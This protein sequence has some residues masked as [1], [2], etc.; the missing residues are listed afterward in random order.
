MF[1]TLFISNIWF[2]LSL[3]VMVYSSDYYL[4]LYCATLYH[5]HLKEHIVFEGSFELTPY[6]GADVDTL[7]RISPRF[8]WALTLSLLLI[9]LLWLL[10]VYVLPLPDVF[11]F[12]IGGLLLR[13]A[14]VHLRHGRNL[15]LMRLTRTGGGLTGKVTYARWLL[16]KLSALEL[17][18]FAGF[19]LL[20]ALGW[21]SWFFVGGGVF[22]LFTGLQ[23]WRLSS[24]VVL[25]SVQQG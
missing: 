1:E 22:C 24:K 14:A 9:G 19:F 10:T 12:A 23:H 3:W 7:R 16:L 17:W 25:V 21:A 8:I 13:E 2:V 6:F 5:T 18:V 20:I 11:S 15:A 4:T